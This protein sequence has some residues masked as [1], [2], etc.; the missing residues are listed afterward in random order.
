[1]EN[2]D[3]LFGYLVAVYIDQGFTVD[4]ACKLA[5]RP[6]LRELDHESRDHEA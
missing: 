2:I 5:A 1:M 6:I 3:E 4:T